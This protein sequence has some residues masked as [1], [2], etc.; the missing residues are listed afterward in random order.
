MRRSNHENDLSPQPVPGTAGAVSSLP[1][2]GCAPYLAARLQAMAE[3]ETIIIAANT[4]RLVGNRVEFRDLGAVEV[5]GIAQ[6]VPAWQGAASECRREPVREL[7]GSALSH[8]I[9]RD[10]EIADW[11]SPTTS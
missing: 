4:R 9:G 11:L 7:R 2:L 3:P 1:L 10:E 8:L 5:K 6:R